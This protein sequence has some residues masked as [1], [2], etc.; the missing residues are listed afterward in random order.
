[1]SNRW[2]IIAVVALSV[3][4]VGCGGGGGGG[5]DGGFPPGSVYGTT[6]DSIGQILPG[7]TFVF[8]DTNLNTVAT[9]TS[10]AN[11]QF[12]FVPNFPVRYLYVQSAPSAV[13][14][15]FMYSNVASPKHLRV[16][17]P[18]STCLFEILPNP[19]ASGG[20]IGTFIF[21]NRNG[22]PPPI[23]EDCDLTR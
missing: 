17:Q 16:Y 5:G 9:V 1:M 6:R 14:M 11:G 21:Y 7:V 23:P 10:D 4:L 22:G 15:G 20:S 8:L 2:W 12:V 18:L 13:S 3:G 19:T